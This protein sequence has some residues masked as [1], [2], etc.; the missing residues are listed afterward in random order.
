MAKALDGVTTIVE[1]CCDFVWPFGFVHELA[2]LAAGGVALD[3][4]MG[5]DNVIDFKG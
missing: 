4:N 3:L 5:A 1:S 2:H